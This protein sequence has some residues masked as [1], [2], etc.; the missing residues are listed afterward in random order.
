MIYLVNF[1]LAEIAAYLTYSNYL[2]SPLY[3]FTPFPVE[4][5]IFAIPLIGLIFK[6]PFSFYFYSILVFFNLSPFLSRSEFFEGVLD[7]LY[8]MGFREISETLYSAFSSYNGNSTV[9]ITVTWLYI[10]AE[11]FQGKWESIR[12]AKMNGVLCDRCYLAYIPILLFSLA[13]FL[14]YPS[15]MNLKLHFE[16]DRILAAVLGILTFLAG[17]YILA[18][19]A[20][21]EDI[22][23]A[24]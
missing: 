21:E 23:S 7:T 9:L 4:V 22:N 14:L 6:R 5:I 12:A 3:L 16:I 13:V 10:T 15:F 2:S 19:S 24:E 18:K 8:A 1:V 11:V 20:E 17:A